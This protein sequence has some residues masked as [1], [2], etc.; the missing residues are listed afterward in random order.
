MSKYLIAIRYGLI[1]GVAT[2]L[3]YLTLY[4]VTGKLETGVFLG[5]LVFA[6]GLGIMYFIGISRRN[7]LGG[8]INWK[9]AMTHIWVGAMISVILSTLFTIILYNFIDPSLIEQLKELQIKTLESF[10]NNLG[11]K[12]TDEQI[13]KIQ[14]S[15]PFGFLNSLLLIAGGIVVQFLFSCI[16]ALAV[17]KEDPNIPNSS[18]SSIKDHF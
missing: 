17:K 2:I 12:A 14:N 18:N 15:N 5:F 8:Y 9:E 6:A 13:D 4:L 16:I 10:R 3:F 11:D 1:W 7:E